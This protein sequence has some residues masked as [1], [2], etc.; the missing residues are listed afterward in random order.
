MTSRTLIIGKNGKTGSRVE[1]LLQRAGRETRAVSRCTLPAFDWGEPGAWSE[2]M[3]GCDSAYVC[4]QPDL[5]IPA[6]EGAIAE[7]IRQARN[8]GIRHLVLLSGRGEE[9]A[10]R[11]ERLVMN[12]GL[13]WNVV[14]ASWFVQN[15]SE[16]FLI[17]GVI[18][19]QLALPAGDIPEPFID[20]DDIAEVAAACLTK[21]E[22][23]N[24]LF[25]VT[26]PELLSFRGCV[27]IL[28][29]VLQKPIEFL[30]I[31]IDEFLGGLGQVGLSEA[32]LWLMN[33]LF[34]VV[35][36]GRNSRVANGVDDALGR[37]PRTFREYAEK[38]A[39]SGAWGPIGNGNEMG[40]AV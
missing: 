39:A 4:F 3:A 12:S 10:E 38:A 28:A 36:D 31:S 35:M 22:L 27:E 18:S 40:M 5:A 29:E 19:G 24:R 9:G 2:V 20:V 8:A 14:R 21:P 33:E 6:A 16:G 17:E 13:R 30:P 26:G 25:E 34:A 11:A 15:F 1:A 32:E 37:R 7:F 23:G